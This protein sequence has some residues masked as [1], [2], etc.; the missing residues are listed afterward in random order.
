MPLLSIITPAW[1]PSQGHASFLR[2]AFQSL[3]KQEGLGEWEWEWLIQEDGENPW[4]RGELPDDPRIRYSANGRRFGEAASRSLALQRAQGS[5]IRSL[6]SDDVLLPRGL[7]VPLELLAEY[8]HAVWA[9]GERWELIMPE[10][11]TVRDP[12]TTALEGGL[13]PRMRLLELMRES[14]Q[15]VIHCAGLTIRT[16]VFRA[17]GGWMALPRSHDIVALL[18][19]NLFYAGAYSSEPT[20]LYRRWPGQE[21]KQDWWKDLQPVARSILWQRIAALREIQAIGGCESSSL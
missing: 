7:A 19:V 13:V 12:L 6:D 21:T 2:D 1:A 4:L 8:P 16:N 17:F 18:T 11:R 20:F 14:S 9:A 3:I 15:F 10:G 5:L